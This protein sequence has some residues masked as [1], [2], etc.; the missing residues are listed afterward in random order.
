[1]DNSRDRAVRCKQ[2]PCAVARPR[3]SS[4]E[5]SR[6]AT[7]FTGPAANNQATGLA[8]DTEI[9]VGDSTSGSGFGLKFKP[10]STVLPETQACR[11]ARD[12]PDLTIAAILTHALV[13]CG[14]VPSARFL[15]AGSKLARLPH[16]VS[17]AFESTGPLEKSTIFYATFPGLLTIILLTRSVS[18]C[19][20]ARGSLEEQGTRDSTSQFNQSE[21]APMSPMPD[22]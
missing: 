11:K 6:L 9:R 5:P 17:S 22:T 8:D 4:A 1:M 10:N 18:G 21:A 13:P 20:R 15:D 3:L 2:P 14:L 12:A 19:V 7:S 16:D